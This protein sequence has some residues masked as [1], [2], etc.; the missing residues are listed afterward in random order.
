MDLVSPDDILNACK[1]LQDLPELQLKLVK[2]KS[3]LLVV[4][5]QS[6]DN[7]ELLAKTV[8]Y[9]EQAG[10]LTPLQLSA[11]LSVSVQLAR[12]R[13]EEAESVGRLCRDESLEGLKFF[14]NKFIFPPPQDRLKVE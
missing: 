8:Q 14:P 13:L 6:C 2:Y 10:A 4:Q 3:G 9:V 12:Q 7:E 1:Q 5:N 11:R